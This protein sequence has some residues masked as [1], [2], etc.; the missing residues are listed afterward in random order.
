M[1]AWTTISNALVAVGAKPF[2]TTAQA[3]RD[4]PIAL[5]EG[6]AGAPR[7]QLPAL[8]RLVIGSTIKLRSDTVQSTSLTT[9]VAKTGFTIDTMQTGDI[10]VEFE[11]KVNVAPAEARLLRTRG[12]S[13]AATSV[14]T[15][16]GTTYA[17]RSIDWT[18]QPGD[19]VVL[20]FRGG[21]GNTIDVRNVRLLL[22][23]AV[24]Y[25]PCGANFGLIEGNPTIT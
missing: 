21:G 13:N 1:T 22:D 5:A 3:L 25:W 11:A 20:E 14:T 16:T 8:E 7:I 18:V 9:F 12:G 2:A 24:Y 23:P 15:I 17:V 19:H 10:R 6:A 4:N